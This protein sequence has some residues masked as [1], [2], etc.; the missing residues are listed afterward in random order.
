MLESSAQHT[1]STILLEIHGLFVGHDIGKIEGKRYWIQLYHTVIDPNR[2]A[3]SDVNRFYPLS[4]FCFALHSQLDV[5]LMKSSLIINFLL[6]LKYF[7]LFKIKLEIL[8]PILFSTSFGS[9]YLYYFTNFSDF[10]IYIAFVLRV[11]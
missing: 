6:N 10:E 1:V 5:D 4:S 8:K 2:N 9:R 3:I 11:G 7:R